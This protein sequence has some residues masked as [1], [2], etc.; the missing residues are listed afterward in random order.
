MISLR[1]RVLIEARARNLDPEAALQ[2]HW[3]QMFRGDIVGP[4]FA[5]SVFLLFYYIAV[6]FFVVFFATTFGY[7]EEKANALANWYWIANAITLVVTGILSDLLKV[8]KPF[9]VVGGVIS[10]I[11]SALF[12]IATTNA[13]SY[14]HF[15]WIILLISIGGGMAFAAWMAAFTETVEKHNPAATATG[16][17][18]W[19]SLLRVVVTASLI[20]LIFAIPAVSTLVDKGTN[21]QALATKYSAQLATLQKLDPATQQALA[22]NPEDQSA[23]V[24]AV[25]EIG[26][27]QQSDV[28]KASILSKQYSS[29]LQTAAS[30]DQQTLATLSANPTDQAAGAKAVGEIAQK[31][32]VDQAA[33]VQRLQALGAVPKADITFLLTTG[34]QVQQA[35]DKLTAAGKVPPADLAYLQSNAPGVLAA[36][37]AG[38]QQWQRWW[39]I[40]FAGQI[41][42]FAFIGLLTGRWNPA[43]ARRDA[44]EHE[45][46]VQRE[47]AAINA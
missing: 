1:D 31:F 36:Q 3:R 17:A 20:G 10:A 13:T 40:C 23:Q 18:V 8:R 39:W 11:G 28:V 37:K 29:Q 24:K 22:K 47:L 5:I 21:V 38:P 6:G 41:V 4:A 12:A 7:S 44:E 35:A 9:M 19:G 2:G 16:L 26:N 42:F 45:A 34:T 33:A 43:A 25:S 27:V 46:A 30:V 32:G 14:Y 15:A